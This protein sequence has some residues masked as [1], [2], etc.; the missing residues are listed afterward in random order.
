MVGKTMLPPG[1][2]VQS[3]EA[4]EYLAKSKGVTDDVYIVARRGEFRDSMGAYGKNDI[5]IYDDAMWVVGPEY[6][7]S[8]NGNTDPSKHEEGIAILNPGVHPYR[9]GPHKKMR[10]ALR[11]NTKNE[12]LPVTRWGDKRTGLMGYAI[13][14]HRGGLTTTGSAGCQTIHPDQWN[15]FIT[16]V[17]RLMD[18]HDMDQIMYVLCVKNDLP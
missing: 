8:F 7:R 2:P 5:G 12:A 4:I 16:N 18:E 1:R 11:P 14:I 13:N 15:E 3:R 17:Y 9:K 6:F 10:F